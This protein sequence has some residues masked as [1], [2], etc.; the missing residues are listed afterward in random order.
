M[1]LEELLVSVGIDTEDLTS[2]AA[3][4]ADDVESSLGGIQGAAAGAAVGGLFAAGLSN[5]MDATAANTKLANQ[6]GLTSEE[7]ERAGGVAGDVFSAGFG[8]SIDGVSEALGAVT[9]NIGGLGKATDAELDQMTRSAL[10]LADTFE[11]DV[12]ESTQA[13][14]T[15]IKTGMAKDGIEAFDLL[16]AAAQK[17]PP[18]LRE[19]VPAMISEYGEFF[20]QLGFSGPDAMGLLAQAAQDPTF[21]L[22]KLGDAV[23]E[24]TLQMADTAKVEKP[25]KQLGLKVKD[26]QK[27]MNTGHGTEA[28]DQVT[29]A[30]KNVEDQTKRTSIQAALFGGP[31]EDMG[32]SLL[33]LDATGAAAATGLDK[34]KGAAKGVTD[35]VAASKSMDAIMRTLATTV[36]ELLAPALKVLADFMKENPGLI[37]VLAPILVGLAAAIGIAVVAQWAWNAALWAWPG[38]WIIAGIMALV[39]VIVL[40]V[41][42]WDQIAAKTGEV[43]D[44][45]VGKLGEAW[46]WIAQ[47]A[48]ATWDWITSKLSDAWEWIKSTLGDAWD[49]ITDKTGAAW[50]W[51]T[52]KIQGAVQA[53]IDAV[54]W[55]SKIPGRVAG[56]L[57]D[58]V[59]WVAGLPGRIAKAARGMWDS[60]VSGFKSAV[61][62]LIGMWNGLSFTLGGGSFM[63]V[64]I[65]TVRLDT[66]DIPYLAEGGVTTGPTLAM[67]GEGNEDE[68]VA[69]L[70]KLDGMLRS[71]ANSVRSTG[72]QPREQRV[73]LDVVGADSEFVEFLRAVTRTRAG[74]SIIRLAEEG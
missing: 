33:N 18:K 38:T 8:D 6:L 36:G 64:D 34:A 11:F 22:D 16:T 50:D 55:L 31:G 69:P 14:G 35:S 19:E 53:Q 47:K 65:P 48:V 28:F 42:Y 54:G 21:Q 7:A 37:K 4:A 3:G 62:S 74:G 44:W 27:L 60:I 30:L 23:K 17:L 52:G 56:W 39:A 2:G 15:L 68:V 51:I 59:D 9:S 63:G 13:V 29:T 58:M 46:D 73:V 67:I 43:W 10:A 70:S 61:N 72:G 25:L 26:I 40:I 71:V 57:G 45:I 66:P 20:D 24:F 41:V 49:W 12:G 5:A 32:N 1:T